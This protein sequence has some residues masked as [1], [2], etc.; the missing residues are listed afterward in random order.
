MVPGFPNSEF[1]VESNKL[2]FHEIMFA[3]G[4]IWMTIRTYYF[5]TIHSHDP[6]GA[7]GHLNAMQLATQQYDR[8]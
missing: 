8:L 5:R 4:N 6:H 2:Q 1:K 3:K 7:T